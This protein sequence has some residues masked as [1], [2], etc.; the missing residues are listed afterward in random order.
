MIRRPPRS[1]LFPYTTLFRSHSVIGAGEENDFAA[2]GDGARDAKSGDDGFR[3]SVAEGHA[4]VAGH[5]TE[6]LRDFA[7][8]RSLRTDFKT[9]VKLPLDGAFDEVGAM[10]E[11][12]GAEPAE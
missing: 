4:L 12:D 1:T 2:C 9:F 7:G 3:A 10:A 6:H 8:E 5:F 11:D